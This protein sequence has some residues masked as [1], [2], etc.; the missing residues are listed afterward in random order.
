MK[1]PNTILDFNQH[2]WFAKAK[3]LQRLKLDVNCGCEMLGF[4][5]AND[6]ELLLEQEHLHIKTNAALSTRLRQIE[7]DLHRYLNEHG[8]VISR[9]SFTATRDTRLLS[10]NMPNPEWTNPNELRYGKRLKPT[11]EQSTMLKL[12]HRP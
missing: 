9:I 5:Q 2:S 7:P 3:Q 1:T 4:H 6:C 12:K 11:I 10:K 8:W